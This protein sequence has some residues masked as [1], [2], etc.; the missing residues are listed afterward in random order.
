[1]AGRS[2]LPAVLAAV[3]VSASLSASS[4][5]ADS[6]LTNRIVNPGAESGTLDGWKATGFATAAYGSGPLVPSTASA[7]QH[8]FGTYM[9]RG[10]LAGATLSQTVSFADRAAQT[11]AGTQPLSTD[12][13]LGAAG[14]GADGMMMT[15]QPLDA[16]GTSLG[17]AI[18]LGPATANDRQ[19][20]ATLIECRSRTM[21]P[22]GMRS[23][24]VSL[25]ATG[26]S[27]ED[28]AM[29]DNVTVA[30]EIATST[31]YNGDTPA[32]GANCLVRRPTIPVPVGPGQPVPFPS[33]PSM[34]PTPA[35]PVTS[36][37]A[38]SSVRLTRTAI[39]LNAST[40]STLYVTI[41]RRIRPAHSARRGTTRWLTERWLRVHAPAKGLIRRSIRRLPPGQ[42]RV[43][44]TGAA[45]RRTQLRRVTVYPRI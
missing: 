35:T 10:L 1:M 16:N 32:E 33:P 12:A 15:L 44:V 31:E 41:A 45:L 26:G 9:F 20:A 22:I 17:S 19:Q 21:A 18:Q 34:S 36:S 25:T 2:R 23:V 27:G 42:Y 43:T 39:T 29:A 13:W 38:A 5:S 24:R 11:D 4:A 8:G 7:A 28:S 30:S 3:A 37:A 6:D 40:A 14:A